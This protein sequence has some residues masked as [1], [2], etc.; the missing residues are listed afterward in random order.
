MLVKKSWKVPLKCKKWPWKFSRNHMHENFVGVREIF[1]LIYPVKTITKPDFY[2]RENENHTREKITKSVREKLKLCVKKNFRPWK[3]LK[4]SQKWLS[5]ALLIFTGKKNTG[6]WGRNPRTFLH[7][8]FLDLPL[9]PDGVMSGCGRGWA[10][11]CFAATT[12]WCP[13]KF[14]PH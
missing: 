10:A 7:P 6:V 14:K 5:R 13:V 4:K 1:L 9:T 8:I 3:K 12:K 2:V 11:L